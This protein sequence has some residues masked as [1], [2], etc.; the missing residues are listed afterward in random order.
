[1]NEA[2]AV[3]CIRHQALR[4]VSKHIYKATFFSGNENA[5]GGKMQ[6]EMK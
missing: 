5:G 1:M 6:L 3:L 2:D 4:E